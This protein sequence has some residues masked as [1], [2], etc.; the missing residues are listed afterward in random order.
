MRRLRALGHVVLTTPPD[1]VRMEASRKYLRLGYGVVTGAG[2]VLESDYEICI[3][4]DEH[5]VPSDVSD[6]WRLVSIKSMGTK[7]MTDPA[8][9]SAA[10]A[11]A[12]RT[13]QK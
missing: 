5:L 3:E 11:A 4:K 10:K 9:R 1:L 6:T 2:Q 8:I 13:K 7:P 12:A